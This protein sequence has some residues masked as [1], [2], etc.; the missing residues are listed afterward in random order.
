MRIER[1]AAR[2]GRWQLALLIVAILV[3]PVHSAFAVCPVESWMPDPIETVAQN[4]EGAD[5]IGGSGIVPGSG[6]DED[7]IGGSG[8]FGTVTGFGSLCVNGQRVIYEDDVTVT[9]DDRAMDVSELAVGQ[10]VQVS[11]RRESDGIHAVAIDVQHDLSGPITEIGENFFEVMGERLELRPLASEVLVELEIGKR[12][13]VS[14]LRGPDGRL[15]ASRVDWAKDDGRD[16]VRGEPTED[17][18]DHLRIGEVLLVPAANGSVDLVAALAAEGRFLVE[19]RWND[20]AGRFE[21]YGASKSPIT[22]GI[23]SRVDIEGYVTQT[24]DGALEVGGLRFRMDDGSRA[25][26]V[27]VGDRVRV[28]GHRDRE[29][30]PLRATSL[31]RVPERDLLRSLDRS[32]RAPRSD[33]RGIE[34]RGDLKPADR[35][36]RR[37]QH[38][39]FDRHRH[40][41]PERPI[42]PEPRPDL[43]DRRTIDM[44]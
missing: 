21:V 5:G 24:A 40:H 26:E 36:E 34:P 27:Q 17:D 7:G 32:W 15:I 38:E 13:S 3:I 19:G 22:S 33:L 1:I 16:L 20:D 39:R 2:R 6:G 44:M 4:E 12:V 29:R 23:D 43:V 30:G 18:R 28:R 31:R 25:D 35:P 37:P 9:V 8:I 10:V 41:R 42:R 11:T 14:G